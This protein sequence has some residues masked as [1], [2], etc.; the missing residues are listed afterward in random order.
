MYLLLSVELHTSYY[1]LNPGGRALLTLNLLVLTP[2][3]YSPHQGREALNTV[4]LSLGLTQADRE[5]GELTG[6]A[7]LV[8]K[9]R[10]KSLRITL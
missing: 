9:A 5:S 6:H 10:G 7:S 4:L 2:N 3:P 1:P 8:L